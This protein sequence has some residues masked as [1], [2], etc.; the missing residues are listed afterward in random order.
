MVQL[1]DDKLARI[2]YIFFL[3]QKMLDLPIDIF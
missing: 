1:G 2:S 3:K